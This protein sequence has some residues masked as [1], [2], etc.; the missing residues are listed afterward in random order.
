[1]IQFINMDFDG[2]QWWVEYLEG[3]II[4]KQYFNSQLSAN[5]FYLSII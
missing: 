3:S 5:E 4:K 1:M 2:N